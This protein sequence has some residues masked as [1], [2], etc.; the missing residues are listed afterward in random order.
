VTSWL[1]GKHVV[2][3]EVADEESYSIVKEIESLG[4]QSGAPRS[5]VKPTIVNCGEL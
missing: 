2:F 4:S 5:N 1:D 3:G